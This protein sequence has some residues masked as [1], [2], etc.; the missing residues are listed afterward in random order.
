MTTRRTPSRNERLICVVAGVAF[1]AALLMVHV[2]FRR[3]GL[4]ANSGDPYGYGK[5]AHGLVEHGFTKLTRRAASL[6]PELL[7]IIYRVGLDDS[8]VQLLQCSFHVGTCVLTFAIGRRVF[9]TRTGLIAGLFCA[10]HPMLLRYVPDLHMES[11]LT[12]LFAVT[13]WRA[14][15]FHERP[16]ILNGVSF[17]VA[18]TLATLSKG[19]ALPMMVAFIAYWA[20]RWWRK[21]PGAA[22]SLPGVVGITLT[23]AVMIAPWTYRNYKVSGKVVLLTPGTPDAF[24]R[25]YIFTRLE[26]A[27]LQQPPYT[28]AENESNALLRRIAHENGVEWEADELVDDVNNGKVVKQWIVERPFDTLRKCVVGL[29]TF[30]YEMTSFKS[31]LIPFV[32][33]IGNFIFAAIGIKRAHEEKKPFPI[34]L[35][36]VVVTNVFVAAL[37]PLGRYSVPILPFLAV[38]AAYGV[39]TWLDRRH[40]ATSGP[41]PA[42]SA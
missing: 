32:L 24:L 33:A 11:F 39:D 21:R 16:T 13:I 38:L 31:S 7:A 42:V 29:F 34:L 4:V 2:V 28:I 35:L 23:M 8:A 40:A 3:Q 19:V 20:F 25:G 12:F 27:T 9:N 5:I 22:R 36:P 30:W 18:G 15:H 41:R 6:Y 26:F 1:V 37:I 10:L 17:A 14:V